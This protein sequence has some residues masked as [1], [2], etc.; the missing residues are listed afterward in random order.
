[1]IDLLIGM[2]MVDFSF[3]ECHWW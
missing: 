1:L 3:R 2:V